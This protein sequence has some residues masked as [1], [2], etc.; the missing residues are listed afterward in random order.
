MVVTIF[1]TLFRFVLKVLCSLAQK[2]LQVGQL[3]T[4]R[5]LAQAKCWVNTGCV[6]RLE[7]LYVSLLFF[8][9]QSKHFAVDTLVRYSHYVA[10]FQTV[11]PSFFSK[12]SLSPSHYSLPSTSRFLSVC[13]PFLS[14]SGLGS[15][16]TFYPWAT[17]PLTLAWSL[18][19]T[20]KPR[21]QVRCVFLIF[22]EICFERVSV[23]LCVCLCVFC[24]AY[25]FNH[26]DKYVV[27]LGLSV[28]YCGVLPKS[29]K[30]ASLYVRLN[31]LC[32]E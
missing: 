11:V 27:L 19:S 29:I 16:V 4:A 6:W 31:P 5:C 12:I 26:K 28:F 2:E 14:V 8:C 24:S 21:P 10:V 3:H 18:T 25:C 9:S 23:L 1:K 32:F 15:L 13:S 17:R 22:S 30:S 20:T 7:L